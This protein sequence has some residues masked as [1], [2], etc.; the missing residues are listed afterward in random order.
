MWRV[1]GEVDLELVELRRFVAIA[2]ALSFRGAAERLG[3]AQPSLSRTVAEVER[4]LGT[5]ILE[6][7]TRHVSLTPAGAVLLEQSRVVL[8]AVAAAA[9]RTTRAGARQ[10]RLVLAIKPGVGVRTLQ[11]LVARF[12]RQSAGPKVT[13]RIG[14]WGEPAA[15]LAD[16]RADVAL[17]HGP[18]TTPGLDAEP[19]FSEPRLVAL[20]ADHPLAKKRSVRRM[21]LAT[22]AVPVWPPASPLLAAY[23]AAVDGI[24]GGL[25]RVPA[26]P[27]VHDVSQLL[28]AVALGQGVAFV[29]ASTAR[30]HRRRDVAY[31]RVTDISPITVYV[32]WAETC[33]SKDVARFVRLAIE[34]A[35]ELGSKA[36][37][38]A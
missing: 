23:R 17:L 36:A 27:P 26:G 14:G 16:G 10:R 31:I 38:L 34:V 19:L 37:E 29:P 21:D 9:R 35:S 22:E 18:L 3:V 32:A 4:K 15:M 12:E 1:P 2:E 20:A 8:N 11:R 5:R 13:V 33:R 6:R 28:E 24:E 7:T 30:L 25:E